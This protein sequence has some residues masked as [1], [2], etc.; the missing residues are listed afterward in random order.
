L[1]THKH[2]Y[3]TYL[4]AKAKND[5]EIAIQ[6]LSSQMLRL[7]GSNLNTIQLSKTGLKRNGRLEIIL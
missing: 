1:H 3:F 5:T 6:I 4:Q 2:A 7:V